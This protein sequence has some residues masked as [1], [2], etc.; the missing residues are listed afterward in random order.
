M[1]EGT[2]GFKSLRMCEAGLKTNRAPHMERL[3]LLHQKYCPNRPL[4]VKSWMLQVKA[5]AGEEPL[6]RG[7]AGEFS[8]FARVFQVQSASM[9]SWAVPR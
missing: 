4:A 5:Q 3:N 7:T 8:W 1:C 9:C 2:D 6:M